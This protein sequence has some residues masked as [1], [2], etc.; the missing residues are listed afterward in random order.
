MSC[1]QEVLALH[2]PP[3]PLG[4]DGGDESLDSRPGPVATP[5]R[6]QRQVRAEERQQ[7]DAALEIVIQ[8]RELARH[9]PP[10]LVADQAPGS[11]EHRQLVHGD[12]QINLAGVPPGVGVR[13]GLLLHDARV[14]PQPLVA[15]HREQEA[16]L[17]LEQHLCPDRPL[18]MAMRWPC[19]MSRVATNS[20]PP[21]T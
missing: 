12:G 19:T 13:L 1:L 10:H 2:A 18:S 4:D 14:G 16:H 3:P 11:D 5:E 6:R 21:G 7:I 9:P 8:V 15:Q 20:K 17:L